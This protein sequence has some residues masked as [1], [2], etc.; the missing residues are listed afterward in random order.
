MLGCSIICINRSIICRFPDVFDIQTN[1]QYHSDQH[2]L[3]T[4]CQAVKFK[5]FNYS[6]L[7]VFEHICCKPLHFLNSLSSF[8]EHNFCVEIQV[9]I[10]ANGISSLAI[11]G[12]VSPASWKCSEEF[13][14]HQIKSRDPL[15]LGLVSKILHSVLIKLLAIY[16]FV[17]FLKGIVILTKCLPFSCLQVS[18]CVGT[19][20]SAS[21]IALGSSKF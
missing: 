6:Y 21:T 5:M 4:E 19:A 14:S 7:K 15:K 2:I 16:Y 17:F 20:V 3:I 12:G 10:Y 18:K 13:F 11:Q 8:K 1:R 9:F